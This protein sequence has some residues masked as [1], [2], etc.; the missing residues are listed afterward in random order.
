MRKRKKH[1]NLIGCL[2][3]MGLLGLCGC[4]SPSSESE[5]NMEQQGSAASGENAGADEMAEKDEQGAQADPSETELIYENSMELQYAKNFSVDYYKG[6]YTMLTTTTDGAQYLVVPED[7]PIP[8]HLDASVVVLKQPLNHL[9]LVASAAMDMFREL[10]AVDRIRFSGQK[11]DGWY[12]DEA[13]LAMEAGEM[14][15][16]GKYSV[17]DYELI[18]SEGCSLAIENTMISHSPEVVE[19]LNEFGIPVLIDYSS[20]ETHPLGRVEW[21]RFYGAL[22]GKE[23][24]AEDAFEKQLKILERISKEERTDTEG[25]V[26]KETSADQTVAFFYITSNGTVNVRKTA[27]YVPQMIDL[28]GGSYIFQDLGS[29]EDHRSTVNMT[30]E[31]F[32]ATAKDADYLIY[33]STIDGEIQ[34]VA[35]LL[36]KSEMLSRFRAVQEGNVWCTTSDLYQHSM[37]VGNFTLDLHA[38]LTGDRAHEYKYLYSLK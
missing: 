1:I 37:S 16:A 21:I 36:G 2:F 4:G 32:Y 35:E 3:L 30:M 18:V 25:Y 6:G 22:L 24:A 38:M 5:M 8:E 29:D 14:L 26:E 12:I 10:D 28:A 23:K 11:V 15:Y 7:Q 13:K 17:P 19:K 27:D 33:N 34:T 9:Y 20:Y 31:Q